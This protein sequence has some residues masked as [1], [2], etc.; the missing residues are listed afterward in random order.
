MQGE[1]GGRRRPARVAVEHGDDDRHVRPADGDDQ[2]HAQHQGQQ[3][4]QGQGP[5]AAGH[6]EV[7][8]QGQGGQP[9]GRVQGMLAGKLD[10]LAADQPLELA[11]GDDRAR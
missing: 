9:E 5:D 4:H 2:R 8:R 1:A 3:G 7:H 6:G 11:E 10:R